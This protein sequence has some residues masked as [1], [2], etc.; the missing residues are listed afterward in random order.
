MDV[1][2]RRRQDLVNIHRCCKAAP[3][4]PCHNIHGCCEA[5]T[6]QS[7]VNSLQRFLCSAKKTYLPLHTVLSVQSSPYSP[8]HTVLSIQSSPYS[9][10][11]TAL[12][13]QPPPPQ[14]YD[15]YCPP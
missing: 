8:L 9:P 7:A 12:S 3:P 4:R 11:H 13:I 5:A 6:T 10:L 1:E 15:V 14:Y 2:R